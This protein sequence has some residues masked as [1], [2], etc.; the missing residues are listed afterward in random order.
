MRIRSISNSNGVRNVIERGVHHASKLVEGPA[1]EVWAAGHDLAGKALA[2]LP[3]P[4]NVPE[5]SE[6][7]K[8]AAGSVHRLARSLE[9]QASRIDGSLARRSRRSRRS[10]R[11]RQLVLLTIVIAGAAGVRQILNRRKERRQIAAEATTSTGETSG[12]TE[13]QKSHPA[14]PTPSSETANR[15]RP[16]KNTSAP[17]HSTT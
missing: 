6:L 9:G 8:L 7:P 2:Q 11:R 14:T 17:A 3:P 16:T 13:I 4:P 10:R 5:I 12:A 15:I 1:T